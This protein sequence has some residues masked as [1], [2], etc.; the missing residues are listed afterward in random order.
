MLFWTTD[1]SHNDFFNRLYNS[2]NIALTE[3]SETQVATPSSEPC[4][5]RPGTPLRRYVPDNVPRARLAP[6]GSQPAAT[7][8]KGWPT[9]RSEEW[10]SRRRSSPERGSR[11][12]DCSGTAHLGRDWIRA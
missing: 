1:W 5:C 8:R 3:F 10:L 11:G 12:C 4:A 7:A 2:A 6:A 9:K